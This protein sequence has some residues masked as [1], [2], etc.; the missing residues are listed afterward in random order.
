MDLITLAIPIYNVQAYVERALLSALDQ[1]HEAIEYLLVDDKGEDHSM[2]IVNG[3]I[4]AHPRGGAVKV[5]EHPANLGLGAARNTAMD[6]ANGEYLFFMDSDD[7]ITPDCIEKL[8][9]EML[10][11]GV[12]LVIGSFPGVTARKDRL[13]ERDRERIVLSYFAKHAY[14]GACNKLYKTSFLRKNNIRCIHPIMEDNYFSLKVLLYARGYSLIPDVTYLR[15]PREDSITGGG[16]GNV[17]TFRQF[18]QM[19]T[20]MARLIESALPEASLRLKVKGKFF[21]RRWGIAELAMQSPYNVRTY[22]RDYLSPTFLRDRDLV[23]SPFL[24]CAYILSILPLWM[25]KVGLFIHI[26]LS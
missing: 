20:D 9:Q 5:V 24:F 1:T 18:P 11:T 12:D 7:A 22:I 17:Q 2:H 3:I 10:R 8:Y 26:K 21:K 19:L 6:R 16:G 4:A 15:Y 14:I 25:K 13:V 23:R